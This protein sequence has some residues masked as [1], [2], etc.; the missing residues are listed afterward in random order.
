MTHFTR[1]TWSRLAFFVAAMVFA[2][3]S[4]AAG[5]VA[6]Q[7][8]HLIRQSFTEYNSAME[9]GDS[10]AFVKYFASDAKYE[11][12]LVQLSGRE[13]LAR[14]IGAEFKAYKARYQ[15]K[16]VYLQDNTAAV[17]MTWEG[18][19]RESGDDVRLD[20]VGLFEVGSSGQFSSAVLYFDSA[21]AAALAKRLK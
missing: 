12:P 4:H 3:A 17:V 5:S 13:E 20:M 15:V 1:P 11:S 8:E 18:T 2:T 16:K 21:K 9:E 6:M 10:A 19:D 14:H 7:L